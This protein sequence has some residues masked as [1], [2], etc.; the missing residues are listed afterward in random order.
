LSNLGS[1]VTEKK[2]M[3]EFK[4]FGDVLDISL[5]R[6]NGRSNY[7]GYVVMKSRSAAERA[8]KEINKSLD[9]RVT[10]Y[11]KDEKRD[12]HRSKSSSFSRS[13]SRSRSRSENNLRN[14]DE[15][16]ITQEAEKRPEDNKPIRVREIW[17]GNLPN[18]ITEQSLYNQFF[19]FGEIAKMDPHF[20]HDKNY[21]FIKYR[22]SASASRAYEKAKNMNFNGNIIRVSFSDSGKRR[23]IIGD[24]AG[25]EVNEKT[26][27][28]LH[29][30]LNKGSQ[31]ASEQLLKDMFKKYGTIKGFHIKNSPGFR[32]AI[33]LEYSKPE[34]TQVALENLTTLD[35]NNE[36]RTIIGDPNCDI[37][38]YFKKKINAQQFFNNQNQNMNMNNP[39]M[40]N[41]NMMNP[42]MN[43][44]MRMMNPYMMNPMMN[45]QLSKY[46]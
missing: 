22:L 10:L 4:Y 18:N 26:C 33:Y 9:W 31:V 43:P 45:P 19:I 20:Q 13:R 16:K 34:E 7:F 3:D 37:N 15:N 14:E 12:R 1:S 46:K 25:Y 44:Q 28:M 38:Y 27:K 8:M 39:N 5:R 42:F 6:K 2:V 23:D 17:V 40:M 29:L 41:P 30:S 36:K 11:D 21:A 24:E 35:T 32:P